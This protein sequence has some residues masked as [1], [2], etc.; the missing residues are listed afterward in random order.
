MIWGAVMRVGA[1]C[2]VSTLKRLNVAVRSILVG[3]FIWII[4]TTDFSGGLAA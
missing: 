1:A 4:C 2:A 3:R